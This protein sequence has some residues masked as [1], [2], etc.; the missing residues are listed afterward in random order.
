MTNADREKA[1]DDVRTRLER[2]TQPDRKRA[3]QLAHRFA[4]YMFFVRTRSPSLKRAGGL[5]RGRT[6]TG[7]IWRPSTFQPEQSGAAVCR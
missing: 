1:P 6:S 5:L 7:T 3:W 4:E 2:C